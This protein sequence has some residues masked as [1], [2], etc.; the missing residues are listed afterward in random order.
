MLDELHHPLVAQMIEEPT[1]VRIEYPVHSLPVDSHVQ[2]IQRL[3]RA[4]SR[5]KPIRK[6]PKIHLIYLVEDG[7]HRLLD[8]L[9]FQRSDAQRP[10]PA[11]SLRYVHS[12]RGLR[13]IRSTVH[14]AMEFGKPNLQVMFILL[15]T[16]SVYSGRCAPL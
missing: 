9:V 12:S 7:H 1:N 5:T 6:A 3:V 8:N 14:S 15:P 16:Y 10:L 13:P 4:A 11:I 2:R